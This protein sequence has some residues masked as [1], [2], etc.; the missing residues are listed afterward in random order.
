M[1]I[2]ISCRWE[3]QKT[4][5]EIEILYE[6][7]KADAMKLIKLETRVKFSV[8]EKQEYFRRSEKKSSEVLRIQCCKL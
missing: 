7:T 2:D 5:E 6:E 8:K 1:K 3:E 4:M